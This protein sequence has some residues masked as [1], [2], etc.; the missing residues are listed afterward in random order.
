MKKVFSFI[1]LILVVTLLVFA[2]TFP[3]LA[4]PVD[5]P[6]P[7]WLHADSTFVLSIAL[8]AGALGVVMRWSKDPRVMTMRK[9][10][11]IIQFL[12]L[13]LVLAFAFPALAE[14]GTAMEPV[15]FTDWFK[16]NLTYI[17]AAALA[18]S[19]LLAVTPW[20][21]GNGILDSIIKALN[22]FRGKNRREPADGTAEGN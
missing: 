15:T 12:T 22:F 6:V 14:T 21:K 5:P 13:I 10:F 8:M 4:A 19:E 1:N 11:R 7:G 9:R 20:F 18:V 17:L 3:V 2:F 16:E